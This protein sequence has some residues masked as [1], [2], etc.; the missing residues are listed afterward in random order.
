M[1]IHKSL[2]LPASKRSGWLIT[3]RAVHSSTQWIKKMEFSTSRIATFHRKIQPHTTHI[4]L[5]NWNEVNLT[6]QVYLWT[7]ESRWIVWETQIFN[8][9]EVDSSE[10]CCSELW[11]QLLCSVRRRLKG[12]MRES[13]RISKLRLSLSGTK[14]KTNM[15]TVDPTEVTSKSKFTRVLFK[16]RW[17]GLRAELKSEFAMK[18]AKG[19]AGIPALEARQYAQ[20]GCD[21]GFLCLCWQ[22]LRGRNKTALECGSGID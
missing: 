18:H 20:R 6:R 16:M 22:G 13:R 2:L 4:T 21:C 8:S 19:W 15:A 11:P 5:L 17:I 9:E 7:V 3:G 10:V 14:S 12:T 1:H